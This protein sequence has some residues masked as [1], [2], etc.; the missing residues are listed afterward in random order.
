MRLEE[1]GNTKTN[2]G[3]LFP[4]SVIRIGL[5]VAICFGAAFASLADSPP[6]I[7]L[8]PQSLNAALGAKAKFNVIADG[9][10]PLTYQWQFKGANLAAA[11]D[12]TLTISNATF[13]NAGNYRVIV[14]NASGSVTSSVALLTIIT[15]PVILQQPANAQV[16]LAV[17]RALRWL[18]PAPAR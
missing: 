14:S 17:R 6:S 3:L 11:T 2:S 8:Q 15:P 12:D 5:V 13:I 7:T 9:T 16:L 4:N 18:L 1:S 10:P